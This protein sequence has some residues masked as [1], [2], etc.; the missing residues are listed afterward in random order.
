MSV[1]IFGLDQSLFIPWGWAHCCLSKNCSI[2]SGKWLCGRPKVVSAKPWLMATGPFGK[3]C[4]ESAGMKLGCFHRAHLNGHPP[5]SLQWSLGLGTD[6]IWK[7]SERSCPLQLGLWSSDFWFSCTHPVG[8]YWLP[9]SFGP[10]GLLILAKGR[11]RKLRWS[12]TGVG[13]DPNPKFPSTFRDNM[14]SNVQPPQLWDSK[15]LCLEP[16]RVWYFVIAALANG[17]FSAMDFPKPRWREYLLGPL[18]GLREKVSCPG[19]I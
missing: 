11:C 2:K 17:N 1:A 13:C 5:C 3:A 9:I 6:L 10:R 4:E 7:I 14:A 8:F 18:Q 12:H 19:S 15:F 16:L